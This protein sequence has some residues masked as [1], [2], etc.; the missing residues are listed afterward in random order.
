[1]LLRRFLLLYLISVFPHQNLLPNTQDSPSQAMTTMVIPFYKPEIW[2][3]FWIAN[4]IFL[5]FSLYPQVLLILSPIPTSHLSVL[6]PLHCHHPNHHLLPRLSQPSPNHARVSSF[7][8]W[9][10]PIYST[11][12]AQSPKNKIRLCPFYAQKNSQLFYTFESLCS[13]ILLK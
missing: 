5:P 8:S 12:A 1:M 4:F 3:L 11:A 2:K 10:P 13:A 7:Y 6:F 9:P